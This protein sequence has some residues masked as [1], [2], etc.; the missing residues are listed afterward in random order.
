QAGGVAEGERQVRFSETDAADQ[1]CIGFFLD[2]VELEQ[3]LEL[4]TV[5]FLRPVPLELIERLDEG[6]ARLSD[7]PLETSVFPMGNLAFDQALQILEV[8]PALLDGGLGEL[9]VMGAD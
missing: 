1:D 3:M 8:S 6:E 9:V 5:D 7:A 2:E 4:R